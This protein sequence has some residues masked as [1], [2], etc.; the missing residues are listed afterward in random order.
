MKKNFGPPDPLNSLIRPCNYSNVTN[1]VSDAR[2]YSVHI[3]NKEVCDRM[4]SAFIP[5]QMSWTYITFL[6]KT[7]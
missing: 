2:N 5:L 7:Q 1:C 4:E 6:T 3:S